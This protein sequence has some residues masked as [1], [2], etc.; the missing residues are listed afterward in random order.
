MGGSD[1]S[2][3]LWLRVVL[4]GAWRAL[5]GR[6]PGQFPRVLGLLEAVGRAAPGAVRFRHGARLRLG[7]QA[8]V[9]VQMLREEQPDGKIFDAVD[10]FFPEGEVPAEGRGL[11][12]PQELAM[13]GEAQESFRELVLSLLADQGRREAYLQGPAGEE[14]GEPFLRALERL[15]YEYLQRVE[16]ALPPPDLRQLQEVV[17]SHAPSRLRARDLPMLSQYLMD[18]GHAHCGRV[19]R[20][21]TAAARSARSFP[22]EPLRRSTPSQLRPRPRLCKLHPLPFPPLDFSSDVI[23]D[24]E[25]KTFPRRKARTRP[26]A[27]PDSDRERDRDRHRAH[28]Q[29]GADQGAG[30][31]EGGDP[32]PAAAAHLQRQADERR[33]DGGR[34]QDP[35]R[36]RP[37]SCPGPAR[38]RVVAVRRRGPHLT[39]RLSISPAQYGAGTS[40]P[41]L[42]DPTPS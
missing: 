36:L 5:R 9:V 39:S 21:L 40:L 33:E 7:L 30:G 37:P 6:R 19:P 23:D 24:L 29:G 27:P 17:W 41:T 13:V 10:S 11:A 1:V 15:F 16:S 22:L 25:D 32:P 34:L 42:P 18:M 26:P 38:G 35:G 3:A 4:A 14:Y 28:G 31:G 12:T 2:P 20:P 8:A